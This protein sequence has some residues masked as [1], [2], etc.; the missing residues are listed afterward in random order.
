MDILDFCGCKMY[1]YRFVK[2]YAFALRPLRN[3]LRPLREK[4][5]A[6]AAKGARKERE[7]NLLRPQ[8]G[9]PIQLIVGFAGLY[10]RELVQA[11]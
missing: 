1:V 7:E 9:E 3:R 5:H 6:K 11:S 8:P 10:A 4:L 2:L